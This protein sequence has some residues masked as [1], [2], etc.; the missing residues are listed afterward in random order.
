MGFSKNLDI[1]NSSYH[2]DGEGRIQLCTFL[3]NDKK[4]LVDN[5]YNANTETDQVKTLELLSS[6][7]ENCD[8]LDSEIVIGGDF[9]FIFDKKA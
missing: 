8:P 1:K 4:Y 7:I 5:M 6:M 9:N 3:Y 2:Q